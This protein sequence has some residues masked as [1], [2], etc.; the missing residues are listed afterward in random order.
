MFKKY[1]IEMELPVP[2]VDGT[3]CYVE[4]PVT[5]DGS[6][7]TVYLESA[8]TGLAHWRRE[9]PATNFR[10]IEWEPRKLS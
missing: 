9:F 1:T 7:S 5:P 10:L 6:P 2:S 4:V 8:K 3:Y